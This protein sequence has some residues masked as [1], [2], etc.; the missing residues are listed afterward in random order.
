MREYGLPVLL[1]CAGSEEDISGVF[2]NT[3]RNRAIAATESGYF[4]PVPEGARQGDSLC[5][6]LGARVPFV[7]RFDDGYWILVGESYIYGLMAGEALDGIDLSG[8]EDE[9]AQHPFLDFIIR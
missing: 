8:A 5:I 4:G 3:V 7:L 1:H 9:V 2:H 6:L